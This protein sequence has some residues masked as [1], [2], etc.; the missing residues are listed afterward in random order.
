MDEPIYLSYGDDQVEQQAFLEQAA[1]QVYNYVE[2]QPWTKK[3][4]DLFMKAY[5]DIMSKEVTGANNNT[6]IWRVS[7][8]GEIDLDSK[9]KKERQM[10]EEAAYFI[11]QQMSSL[12]K[13][14]TEKEEKL[15]VFDNSYFTTQFNQYIGN[16]EFGG[17]KDWINSWNNLDPEERH[18]RGTNVRTERLANL[19]DNYSKTLEEGKYNFENSP[20]QD[21]NDFKTKLNNAVSSLRDGT[22]NQQD[23]DALNQ[24]GINPETYFST[25][26]N[27][28]VQLPNGQVITRK[29]YNQLE[30][31]QIAQVEAVKE[32]ERKEKLAAEQLAQ[33]KKLAAQA[34]NRY[35]KYRF[36]GAG[37]NGKLPQV[38]NVYDYINKLASKPSLN[39][40]EQSE[41]VGIFKA[42]ERNGG[43][44]NLSKE[45]LARFDSRY[46]SN[47]S[48]LKK[49]NEVN[50][51]YW[52]SVGKRV[53]QPFM[54]NSEGFDLQR[55]VDENNPSSKA[56]K[57]RA[58]VNM[59]VPI[60]DIPG[61]S[62]EMTKEIWA[63]GLDIVSVLDPEALSGSALAIEAARLR[64]QANP[65]RS[66]FEKWLDYGTGSLGGVQVFGDLML[67][68][69]AGYN[70]YRLGKLINGSTKIAGAIGTAFALKGVPEA[71]DSIMKL[72]TNP[73]S[74]TPRDVQNISYGFMAYMGLRG[75]AKAR[76]K[77]TIEKASS[78]ST[79]KE[80]YLRLS[81]DGKTHDITIDK[82]VADEINQS[83]SY[84]SKKSTEN[85]KILENSKVKEAVE[86]YVEK[87]NEAHPDSKINLEGASVENSSLFGVS[88]RNNAVKSRD[89]KNPD[90]PEYEPIGTTYGPGYLRPW[91]QR[92]WSEHPEPGKGIFERIKEFWSPEPVA[93][94][95]KEVPEV[96]KEEGKAES[97]EGKSEASKEGKKTWEEISKGGSKWKM[98]S[99]AK[100]IKKILKGEHSKNNLSEE[101]FKVGDFSFEANK[102]PNSEAGTLDISV[103]GKTTTISFKNQDNLKAQVLKFLKDNKIKVSLPDGKKKVDMK[104]TAKLLRELKARGIFKRGGTIDK[105]RIQRYKQF[106][107]K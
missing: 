79:T 81:K 86:K 61:L 40:N 93:K 101:A 12:A 94:K 57:E 7:H 102:F 65:N 84:F 5:S 60:K 43:L 104:E 74:M 66:A 3:R 54:D 34:A 76:N 64:D 46:T 6:G 13:A 75:F 9:S 91:Q 47:P 103:G 88:T 67:T 36:I 24:I 42:A 11:Q 69:K 27:T 80:Y 21:L 53:I 72:V 87:Y 22:W 78:N 35:K 107:K 50:G 26:E 25:G 63:T 4:K 37:L 92:V 17:Q 10:Y 16:N 90:A 70:I 49:I 85:K 98:S 99:E 51:F 55:I 95:R 15:P 2:R 19:L 33:R 45:E 31:E 89:V 30:D 62:P 14:K 28:P 8:R 96:N 1:N 39:G 83:H 18:I 100:E 38:D 48:R 97:S 71:K 82:S 20:F 29:Q 58:S 32:K 44:Q 105:Q 68:G 106:I 59:D 73:R 52:D 77:Q 23:I 56:Y 41:L